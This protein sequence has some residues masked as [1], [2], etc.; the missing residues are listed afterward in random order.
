MT[1]EKMIEEIRRIAKKD[2]FV[3]RQFLELAKGAIAIKV[4]GRWVLCIDNRFRLAA[5]SGGPE[6]DAG[7]EAAKVSFVDTDNEPFQ[8]LEELSECL[9]DAI[10]SVNGKPVKWYK[11]PVRLEY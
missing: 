5:Q 6:R 11:N 7:G 2:K 3:V 4:S 1:Q 9:N 10:V 8:T